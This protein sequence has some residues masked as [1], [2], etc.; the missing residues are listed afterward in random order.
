MRSA[1]P[2][3]SKAVASAAAQGRIQAGE[4]AHVRG[5]RAPGFDPIDE[6]GH[7]LFPALSGLEFVQR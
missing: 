6:E 3:S 2:K 1:I 7:A 5:G 4:L